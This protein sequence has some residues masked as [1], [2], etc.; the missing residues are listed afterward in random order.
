[1]L[2]EGDVLTPDL[3]GDASTAEFGEEVNRCLRRI[4]D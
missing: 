3:G 1:V 4:A 2:A